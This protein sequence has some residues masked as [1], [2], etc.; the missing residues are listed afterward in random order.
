MG[1]EVLYVWKP[2]EIALARA[3]EAAQKAAVLDV[4]SSR[5]LEGGSRQL[6]CV[7]VNAR[8]FLDDVLPASFCS[9][10]FSG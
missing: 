6:M 2:I 4:G 1:L 5:L 9:G 8:F 10:R 3:L 7:I